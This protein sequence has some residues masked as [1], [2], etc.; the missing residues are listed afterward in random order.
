MAAL[1]TPL[2][3]FSIYALVRA[4]LR[5]RWVAAVA[6]LLAI[7]PW[8]GRMAW[9]WGPSMGGFYLQF[10]PHPGNVVQLILIPV[11]LAC[12]VRYVGDPAS[13]T[14]KLVAML[15]LACLGGHPMGLLVVDGGVELQSLSSTSHDVMDWERTP[16]SI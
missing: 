14:A 9:E 2:F 12:A 6:A 5:N 11:W 16:R 1:L 13:E 3:F 8:I 4:I 7:G 15:S 10:L